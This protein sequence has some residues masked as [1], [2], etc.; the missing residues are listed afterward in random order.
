M[1]LSF[2]LLCLVLGFVNCSTVIYFLLQTQSLWRL[3]IVPFFVIL[4]L[5]TSPSNKHMLSGRK[6]NLSSN[7]DSLAN[8]ENLDLDF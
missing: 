1:L 3:R 8:S 7:P 5:I 4:V 2:V 6:T